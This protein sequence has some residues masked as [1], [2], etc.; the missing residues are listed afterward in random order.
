MTHR[1]TDLEVDEISLVVKPANK[2]RFTL[3]K[4]EGLSEEAQE[5]IADLHEQAARLPE[6]ER[7]LAALRKEQ[8]GFAPPETAIE[9]DDFPER[10]DFQQELKQLTE[11]ETELEREIRDLQAAG[12]ESQEG[13]DKLGEKLDAVRERR[14]EINNYLLERQE[15]TE[16]LADLDPPIQIDNIVKQEESIVELGRVVLAK[17]DGIGGRKTEY[18]ELSKAAG[19]VVTLACEA[20]GALREQAAVYRRADPAL[21]AEQ[22]VAKAV[23]ELPGSIFYTIS[24]HPLTQRPRREAIEVLKRNAYDHLAAWDNGFLR[25]V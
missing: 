11:V 25:S 4:A 19:E 24:E 2:R 6:L 3:L 10:A 18:I 5:F 23:R 1:L 7:K 20:K 15:L 14:E 17:L 22:A 13:V 21:S 16:A 12:A 8:H 9:D